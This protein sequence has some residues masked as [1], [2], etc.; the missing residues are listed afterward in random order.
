MPE[1][2]LPTKTRKL[3]EKL[4]S[5]AFAELFDLMKTFSFETEKKIKDE[6]AHEHEKN[7]LKLEQKL[8]GLEG[9]LIKE[10][11]NIK[12]ELKLDITENKAEIIKWMFIFW[13]GSVFI[14]IG[15][16]IGFLSLILK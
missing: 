7:D 15:G 2:V 4:G 11:K 1:L 8:S 3:E 9:R 10:I 13:T 16:I 5:P 14:I 12:S 6:H